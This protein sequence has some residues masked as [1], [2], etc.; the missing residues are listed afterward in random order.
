MRRPIA[1]MAFALLVLVLVSC[2]AATDSS[3]VAPSTSTDR[4]DD[5]VGRDALV[6]RVIDG[7]TIVVDDGERI[8]LIGI[9]TPETVRPGTPIECFGKAASR[10]LSELLPVGTEVRLVADVE[11]LDRYDRTLSYV[12][13]TRDGLFI[14]ATMVEAGFAYAYTYPPN[15]AH[16]DEFARLQS[17]AQAANRGLWAECPPPS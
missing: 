11:P 15:V 9:D 16:A 3:R 14:N 12:Y 10:H 7:D 5:V 1:T 13:R 2:S 17:E 8:R 4:S 6:A